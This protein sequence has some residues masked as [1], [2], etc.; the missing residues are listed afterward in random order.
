MQCITYNGRP[1]EFDLPG[2]KEVNDAYS[3]LAQ[4]M[5]LALGTKDPAFSEKDLPDEAVVAGFCIVNLNEII[6]QLQ[7]LV[8]DLGER[9]GE[10]SADAVELQKKYDTLKDGLN[11]A[12]AANRSLDKELTDLMKRETK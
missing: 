9:L 8:K 6:K 12:L 1:I 2:D 5:V 7:D 11:I 10:V 3:D 4:D